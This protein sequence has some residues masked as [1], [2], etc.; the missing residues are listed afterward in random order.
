[1]RRPHGPWLRTEKLNQTP[2]HGFSPYEIGL[3]L[4]RT[5]SPWGGRAFN[6]VRV[7]LAP[8]PLVPN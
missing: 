8:P 1:M 6:W 7:R 5:R 2:L 4:S 3:P